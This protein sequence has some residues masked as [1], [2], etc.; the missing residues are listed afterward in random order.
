M[1][2]GKAI[3][4]LRKSKDLSQEVLAEKAGITQAALSKIENGTRAGEETLKKIC[5]ALEISASLLQIYAFEREDVPP[6][7]QLLYDQLF[8]VIQQMI[9][10]L[11][12][13]NAD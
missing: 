1:N 13:V 5:E 8:P 9:E 6:Q 3:Q 2:I 4:A 7:K 11:A 10:R 12:N